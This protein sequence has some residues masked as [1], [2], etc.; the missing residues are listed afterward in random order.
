M[1]IISLIIGDEILYSILN[2]KFEY[3]IIK[4]GLYKIKKDINI[5]YFFL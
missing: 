2:G 1:K 4:K 5:I 3:V